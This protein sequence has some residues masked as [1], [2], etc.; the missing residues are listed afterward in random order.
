MAGFVEFFLLII[1]PVA[2]LVYLV[3][4]TQKWPK[5][6]KKCSKLANFKGPYL[7]AGIEIDK[8]G[9]SF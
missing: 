5:T 1:L 3:P 4:P 8:T 2:I 7:G 9:R 6:V